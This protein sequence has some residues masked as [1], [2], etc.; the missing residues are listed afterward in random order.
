MVSL[1]LEK[2]NILRF[3]S[4]HTNPDSPTIQYF[5]LSAVLSAKIHLFHFMITT[6]NQCYF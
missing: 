2:E 4:R 3:K 6:M 1:N 5:P